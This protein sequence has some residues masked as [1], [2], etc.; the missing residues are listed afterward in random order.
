MSF[1][2]FC[3]GWGIVF[4]ICSRRIETPG[5]AGK[6]VRG[7]LGPWGDLALTRTFGVCETGDLG[8]FPGCGVRG[9]RDVLCE[10]G[11]A[12]PPRPVLKV[13]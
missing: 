12:C 7:A 10:L 4:K 11:C 8:G 3:G 6:R 9:V 5:E 1:F 2:C 13:G